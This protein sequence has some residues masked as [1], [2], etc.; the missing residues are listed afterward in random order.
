VQFQQTNVIGV[1]LITPDRIDDERGFFARTWAA[2]EFDARGLHSRVVQRNLAHNGTTGTLRGMHFQRPPHPEVKVISCQYGAIFDVAMDIR[3]DSPTFG[4]WFGAELSQEN[5][6]VLYVPEGCAH[7]Y[8]TLRPDTSVE[9]LI[10][11]F[12]HP[13]VAGGVRWN[14]PF[15]NVRW[16]FEP[17]LM[18]D[19]DRTWPD[20]EPTRVAARW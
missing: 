2:D 12:Y 11:E 3:P 8:L 17:S 1:V 5:R 6:A 15:F 4:Q 7:G 16:P 14:D 10:S 19:R 20:F 9:Y 13:E 18:N